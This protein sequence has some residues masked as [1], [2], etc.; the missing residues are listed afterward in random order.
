MYFRPGL[1]SLLWMSLFVL[2]GTQVSPAASR[3]GEGRE[4]SV[5][6]I[7]SIRGA[8][9]CADFFHGPDAFS[10]LAL[11]ADLVEILEG[12]ASSPG[13]KATYHHN[14]ILKRWGGDKYTLYA[15][16]GL[17]AGHVRDLRNH[18]GWMA[19]L[20][21]DA[22]LRVRCLHSITVSLEWQADFALQFKNR[23]KQ[24][25]SLYRAGIARSYHP[26]LRIQYCF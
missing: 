18:L 15:G 6:G 19:G 10:S 23:Y 26:Y 24:D 17:T 14:L 22:G 13:L 12:N 2:I 21:G 16:P 25:L 20:S 11:T 7:Q 1:T 8:G 4:V 9:F 3:R 5:G